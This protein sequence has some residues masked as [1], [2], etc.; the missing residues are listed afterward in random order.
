MKQYPDESIRGEWMIRGII[1]K[2]RQE[3]IYHSSR[4]LSK[5][6]E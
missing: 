2:R 4:D 3:K 5:V 1:L 6:R